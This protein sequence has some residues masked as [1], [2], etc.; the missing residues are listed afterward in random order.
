MFH[1]HDVIVIGT[2]TAS[3]ST[4]PPTIVLLDDLKRRNVYPVPHGHLADGTKGCVYRANLARNGN[5]NR[6]S[7]VIKVGSIDHN[8]INQL[9]W[10]SAADIAPTMYCAFQCRALVRCPEELCRPLEYN[11]AQYIQDSRSHAVVVVEEMDLTLHQLLQKTF[12]DGCL[13]RQ[14][15]LRLREVSSLVGLAKKVIAAD[16]FVDLHRSNIMARVDNNGNAAKF[17]IVDF[18]NARQVPNQKKALTDIWAFFISMCTADCL[19]FEPAIS[20]EEIRA[21]L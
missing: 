9:K 13:R 15:G 18:G 5:K 6:I 2:P 4:N 8:E 3:Q 7:V 21:M 16:L 17:L 10:A 1:S 19:S 20:E 14:N 12:Q 11:N